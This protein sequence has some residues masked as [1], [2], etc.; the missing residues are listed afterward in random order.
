MWWF[1]THGV[2]VVC[3]LLVCF[4]VFVVVVLFALDSSVLELEAVTNISSID[5]NFTDAS[6]QGSFDTIV[7]CHSVQFSLLQFKILYYINVPGSQCNVIPFS[8]I[9]SQC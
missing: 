2:S 9:V 1:Q 5:G 3:E 7:F 8:Q 6:I 4:F